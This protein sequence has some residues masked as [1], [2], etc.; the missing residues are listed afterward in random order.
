M[1]MKSFAWFDRKSTRS[2]KKHSAQKVEQPTSDIEWNVSCLRLEVESIKKQQEQLQFQGVIDSAQSSRAISSSVLIALL[3]L[4]AH[5]TYF[6]VGGLQAY[7]PKPESNLN[8]VTWM[9]CPDMTNVFNLDLLQTRAE[10]TD[11][12]IANSSFSIKLHGKFSKSV[13]I[14]QYVVSFS[15]NGKKKIQYTLE[16]ETVRAGKPWTFSR[17]I[18]MPLETFTGDVE[19]RIKAVGKLK[20]VSSSTLDLACISAASTL[21]KI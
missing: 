5:L 7:L 17:D 9:Q 2:L 21:S 12:I 8:Q 15:F 1:K 3:F 19:V 4:L 18:S 10:S 14:K 16:G 20:H 6:H 11:E 13:V